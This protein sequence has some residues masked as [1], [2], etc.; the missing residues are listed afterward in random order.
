MYYRVFE[1]REN[2]EGEF[3]RIRGPKGMLDYKPGVWFLS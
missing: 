1:V 3:F 2:K